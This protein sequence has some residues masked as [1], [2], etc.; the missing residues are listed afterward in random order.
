MAINENTLKV[1]YPPTSHKVAWA[2]LRMFI[3]PKVKD[4]PEDNRNNIIARD[5]PPSN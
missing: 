1:T 3:T 5:N 4:K 2:K